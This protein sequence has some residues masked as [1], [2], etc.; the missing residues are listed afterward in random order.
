MKLQVDRDL[1]VPL[2]LQLRGMIE[3]GIVG[4]E[5][6]PG[7]KLPSVRDL[8]QSLGV[9]PMTVAQVYRDLRDATLLETRD[10]QGTFVAGPPPGSLAHPH[11][12]QIQQRL[13]AV[14]DDAFAV[15]L[16]GG[17]LAGIMQTILVRQQ[18]LDT[19]K[20][21]IMVGMYPEPTRDYA[22]TLQATLGP[23]AIVEPRTI[24]EIRDDPAYRNPGLNFDLAIA[25]PNRRKEVAALLPHIRVVALRFSPSPET[26][27][28]L[29]NL[30]PQAAVGLVSHFPDFLPMLKVG[31][32]HYA[33]QITVLRAAVIDTPGMDAVLASANTVVFS[34]GAEAVLSQILPGTAAI[35]YRYGPDLGDI[36][37]TIVPLIAEF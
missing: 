2:G 25:F 12:R 11:R 1:P 13:Q 17:D 8:A 28:A 26:R 22:Q 19:P 36:E 18:S 33:P 7:Q 20:R 35:E 10:R 30:D 23:K 29:A 31:V 32:R 14:V 37:Q 9:A 27:K 15:G 24:S 16:T 6:S 4:G 21:L 3:Y 34:T 5:L